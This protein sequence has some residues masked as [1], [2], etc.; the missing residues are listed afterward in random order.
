MPSGRIILEVFAKIG[1][2]PLLGSRAWEF[3]KKLFNINEFNIN[4][5][6]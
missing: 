5:G 1:L 6:A 3:N 4:N 2:D